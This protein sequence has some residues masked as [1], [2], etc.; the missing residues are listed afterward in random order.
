MAQAAVAVMILAG[1]LLL[2]VMTGA[3]QTVVLGVVGVMFLFEVLLVLVM[4]LF[5]LSHSFNL[6]P[7]EVGARGKM[8]T[9]R[10]PCSDDCY[11]PRGLTLPSFARASDLIFVSVDLEMLPARSERVAPLI[12]ILAWVA[13]G[14]GKPAL[15]VFGIDLTANSF[16][17]SFAR[18]FVVSFAIDGDPS[19]LHSAR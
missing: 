6:H 17:G 15:P 4:R 13:S 1:M 2:G 16:L 9:V 19:A 18:D 7:F 8:S 14:I 10:R 5:P 11:L 3:L 12:A